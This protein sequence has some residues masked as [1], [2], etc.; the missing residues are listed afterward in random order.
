MTD[1][2]IHRH[3]SISS[4]QDEAHRLAALGAPHGTSVVAGVQT[5]GRGTRGRAWASESGGLWLSVVCRPGST[6]GI[7]SLSLRIGLVLAD[8]LERLLPPGTA[9][10]LK[11]PNDLI[12]ANSKVGGILVEARWLGEKLSWV[13]VGV[14]LN[15][16]NLLP[17]ELPRQ[18]TSLGAHGVVLS[19][20]QLAAPVAEAVARASETARPLQSAELEAFRAR[21]WLYGRRIALP[22]PGVARGITREGRLQVVTAQGIVAESAGP[23]ELS[24]GA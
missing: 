2:L 20:E 1:P 17:V 10:S 7:E 23:A 9:V 5:G 13:V 12:L 4:T 3:D 11:W 6:S 15:I 22:I 19:P 18:A 24:L 16:H 8:L 21:D 14:G